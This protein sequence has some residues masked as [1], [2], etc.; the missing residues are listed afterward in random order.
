MHELGITENIV[1]LAVEHA[2]GAKVCRIVLEIG[3]LTAILPESIQ[4]CF[5]VCTQNTLLEEAT[6]EILI[7]PGL[8][9]CIQ[10]GQTLELDQPFGLCDCGSTRLKILQGEEL[11]IKEMEIQDME[12]EVQCA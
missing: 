12:V 1:A 2:K 3:Q 4:F 8:A 5:D 10:C 11:A 7:R 6:L 9:Q